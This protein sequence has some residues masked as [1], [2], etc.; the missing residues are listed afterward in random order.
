MTDFGHVNKEH[1]E[2]IETLDGVYLESNYDPHLLENGS[3]PNF[4]KR[5]IMGPGGHISNA[6]AATLIKKNTK[7]R[8]KWLCL[9]HLSEENNTPHLAYKT[10][11]SI[12]RETVPIHVA[13]RYEASSVLTL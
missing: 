7:G 4:L 9:A 12:L 13:K 2:A 6:E 3:Y 5:R 10:A 8:L 1:S 11:E